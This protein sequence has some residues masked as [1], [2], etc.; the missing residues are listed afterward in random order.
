MRKC[1]SKSIL[2]LS[3][4]RIQRWTLTLAVYQY[5]IVYK[6]GSEIGNADNLSWLPLQGQ[7]REVP[8]PGELV[9]LMEHLALGPVTAIQIKTMTHRDKYLSQ[10]LHFEQ[11]GWPGLVESSLCSYA[12]RKHELSSL[13]DCVLWRTRVVVPCAENRRILDDLHESHQGASRMK[14]RT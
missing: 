2:I 13:H 7:P 10:V 1:E 14:S 8:V 6:I 4:A 12:S 9:L 5:R 3:S 11:H